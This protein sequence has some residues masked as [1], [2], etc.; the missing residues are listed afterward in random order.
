MAEG[1]NQPCVIFR[2][3]NIGA[4]VWAEKMQK[5]G[6]TYIKYSVKIQKHFRKPNESEYKPTNYYFKDDLP[7]LQ[8]VT[9]KAYEFICLQTSKNAEEDIPI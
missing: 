7:K 5:D 6:K 3:D 4:A 2:I 9:A 8:L 1:K